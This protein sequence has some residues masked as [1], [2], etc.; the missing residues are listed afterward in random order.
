MEDQALPL[1]VLGLDFDHLSEQVHKG[2][3]AVFGETDLSA[4]V[5]DVLGTAK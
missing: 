5:W 4:L 2:R 3:R 1:D